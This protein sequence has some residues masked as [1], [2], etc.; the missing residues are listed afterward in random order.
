MTTKIP[1]D[2]MEA[3]W[4]CIDEYVDPDLVPVIARAIL[5]ERNRYKKEREDISLMLEE[6]KNIA[7]NNLLI[8]N[9]LNQEFVRLKSLIKEML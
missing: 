5:A 2:V 4:A 3:A 7:K 8:A 6:V 9:D 1:D